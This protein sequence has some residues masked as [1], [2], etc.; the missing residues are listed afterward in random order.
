[1]T[2]AKREVSI[3]VVWVVCC[4]PGDVRHV[5]STKEKAEAFMAADDRAHVL[6]DYVLDSPERHEGNLQ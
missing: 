1:M 2:E 5:F 4:D 3:S 6:Y